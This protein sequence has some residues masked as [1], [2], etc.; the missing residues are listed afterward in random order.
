MVRPLSRDRDPNAWTL[1]IA[2]CFLI[3]AWI[4]LTIPSKL[5][6]DEIHYVPAARMMLTMVKPLNPEHPLVG[7]ELIAAGIWMFGD[8][9]LGWRFFSWLF[10]G[11][12]L[13]AFGRALWFASLRRWATLAGMLLLATSFAWFMQSRIAMLDMVMAALGMVALWQLAAAVRLPAQGRWRLALAGVSLGLAI[14]AKWSIVPAA[15]LPGL[16]FLVMRIKSD[17]RHFLTARTTGPVQGISLIEAALWLGIVPL[18]VYWASFLP[19]F[20]YQVGAIDPAAP[21]EHH[22]YMLRLQ[23][24]VVKKHPYMSHWWQWVINWRAIWYLYELADGAQRGVVLIG[25]PF[26]ML[27]GLPAL[28]WALWA[29]I[30]RRRYDALAC[31]LLYIVSIGMWPASGKPVQFYY[32]YLLPGTFLMACLALALDDVWRRSDRWRWIA[33][34]SVALAVGMFAFFYPIIS[35]EAL[36]HGK[37]SF[38]RWMWLASWR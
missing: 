25:N 21:L 4:R 15:L 8:N 22:R 5:Y 33:P 23:D 16:T 30:K 10:G 31:A 32:H 28:G 14:G 2:L 9:A 13:Y 38:L 3:L 26:S 17:G 24:S 12:G 36:T 11:I 27:A 18:A 35:A 29:G 19:S 6:F 7:K 20:F 1:F 37:T 34:G